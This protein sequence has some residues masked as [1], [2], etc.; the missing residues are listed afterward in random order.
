MNPLN[1]LVKH[2]AEFLRALRSHK[3][4]VA[5]SGLLFPAARIS[6]AGHFETAVNGAD[7]QVD[8]NIVTT[9]GLQYIVGAALAGVAALSAFYLAPFAGNVTPTS[10]LTAATFS[11]TTTEFISYTVANRVQWVY[12][13][14]VAGSISNSA[15][16]ASFI[17][18]V[19]VSNATL[20]G[21]GLLS[22]N[23]Q[24]GTTGT[25]IAATRF[26]TA[27]TGLNAGDTLTIQYT[28]S[29]SSS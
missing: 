11:T 2:R 17:M 3:Y 28:L 16:L 1:A 25:S 19:G 20:Y 15:S 14:P 24:N 13:A 9:E 26:A 21:A 29:T 22:S 4:E 27:R 8:P 6:I 7:H 18:A 10:S 5:D 23:V 12:A